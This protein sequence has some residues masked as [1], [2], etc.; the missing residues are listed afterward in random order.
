[1]SGAAGR[2][3]DK[4][5][6]QRV[7]TVSRVPE[8]RSEWTDVEGLR[9]HARVGGAGADRVVLVHGIAVSSRYMIPLARELAGD[10][11]VAAVD[12]P[13]FG[14]SARPRRALSVTE[15][16]HALAAW[17]DA[18]ALAQPLLVGNSFGCQVVVDLAAREPSRARGLVLIGPTTDAANRS[19]PNQIARWAVS[20]LVERPSLPPI[21]ALDAAVAGPRRIWSTFRASLRDPIEDKVAAIEV[22]ILVLRGANDPLAPQPWVEHLVARMRRGRLAV[23]PGG[24]HAL[25]HSRPAE[26]AAA[27]RVHLAATSS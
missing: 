22:P 21:V 10:V 23:I 2:L 7:R 3:G 1:M 19:A 12:L 13:G 17:L 18:N 15:L 25:N 6:L 26:V 5:D 4:H 27:V 9:L 14:R 20:P 24:G 11:G 8:L 16:G